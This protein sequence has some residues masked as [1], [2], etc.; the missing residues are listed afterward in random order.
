[1]R[2]KQT[3]RKSTASRDPADPL[4]NRLRILETKRSS[5]GSSGS[6]YLQQHGPNSNSGSSRAS[7][8]AGCGLVSRGK[9]ISFKDDV[10]FKPRLASG[11]GALKEIKRL[12]KST[13]LLIPRS[14]FHRLVREITQNLGEGT[15]NLRYQVAALMALQEATEHYMTSL[16]EDAY[17]CT[18]HAKRVTLFTKDMDLCRKLRRI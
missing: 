5:L 3:A 6:S 4:N 16:F 7:F 17:L 13:D 10:K 11:E 14:V 15:E 12:Q 18:I 8:P 9:Q 2:V 1:M